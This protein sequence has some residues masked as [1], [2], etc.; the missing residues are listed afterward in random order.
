M[1]GRSFRLCFS[2]SATRRAGGMSL[3]SITRGFQYEGLSNAVMGLGD[4][5]GACSL[6]VAGRFFLLRPRTPSPAPRHAFDLA[7]LPADVCSFGFA[8]IKG[9]PGRGTDGFAIDNLPRMRR[10]SNT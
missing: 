4:S 7:P 9:S 2:S 6:V 3:K 5:D 1:S 10:N 8:T